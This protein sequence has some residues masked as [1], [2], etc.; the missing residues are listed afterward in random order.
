M[1]KV[2][3]YIVIFWIANTV[4]A[5]IFNVIFTSKVMKFSELNKKYSKVNLNI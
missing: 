5:I 2:I 4:I 3:K 1:V